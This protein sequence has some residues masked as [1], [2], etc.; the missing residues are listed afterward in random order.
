MGLRGMVSRLSVCMCV[1]GKKTHNSII[2]NDNYL[3]LYQIQYKNNVAYHSLY[4]V[5]IS[6]LFQ[7]VL[8]QCFRTLS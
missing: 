5:N 2:N 8:E 4:G 3:Y 6:N 7:K 1:L